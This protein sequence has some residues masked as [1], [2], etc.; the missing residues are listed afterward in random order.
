MEKQFSKL[1][2]SVVVIV[3]ALVFAS[4]AGSPRP[5][6]TAV[7]EPGEWKGDLVAATAYGSLEGKADKNGT[8]AWLGI[9]YA[10]PPV[11]DLRWQPPL[12]PTPW[13]GVRKATRFSSIAIQHLPLLGWIRGSEDSLYLNV[14]RPASAKKGLPVYVWIH[15]GGNSTGASNAS[16][17]YEGYA[18]ASR[19][20]LVFVSVNYRLG[21]F[22]WF[23][24]PALRTGDPESDSGNFGTLDLI[25]ALEWVR[26]N[27]AAFGGD[28]GNVTIAGE[29]AGAFN[30]V[31]LL[32]A[33]KARGLFHKAV[34]ESAYR[35]KATMADA[36]R[37]AESV[38]L[39]LAVKQGKAKNEEEASILLTSMSK[40]E[41]ARWLRAAK[42]KDLESISKPDLSGMLPFPYPVFDGTVLP[43][44]GFAA[45]AD[46]LRIAD[47]PLLIGTN[48]EETK[49]FQW[50][51]RQ[52]YRD[53]VYQARADIAS[54]NWKAD[55]ADSIADAFDSASSKRQVY[56]Y[57][58]DWGAP[59]KDGKSVLGGASGKKFG[60]FHSLEISFFLQTPSFLR[61]IPTLR[62]ITRAN[63]RGRKDLQSG[64]GAYLTNFIRTGNPN[65]EQANPALPIWRAW[66]FDDPSPSFMVFDADLE[67]ALIRTEEGRTTRES[68]LKRLETEYPE[69]LRTALR[70]LWLK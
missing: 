46:P 67:K 8:L 31:T 24:H 58:F 35:T 18:L 47:V 57:R 29:S 32:E 62:I 2:S 30:V 49:L 70:E 36:E 1:L 50:L 28:P 27:I 64:M 4:C 55:G 25:A 48:K 41:T 21:L 11:G 19:A 13:L 9:P 69:P 17:D 5:A 65:G 3:V 44:D 40:E 26:D 7:F 61:N 33:P 14:W 59:G 15:G 68:V 56:L 20:D 53:P 10:T 54:A 60:A 12:P 66:R 52:D 34:V 6:A 42:P 39:R 37:F 16:S 43:S 22:G 63:E 23:A 51:A 45:L 38:A